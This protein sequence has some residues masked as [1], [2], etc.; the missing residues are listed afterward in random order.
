MPIEEQHNTQVHLAV[1]NLFIDGLNEVD[2]WEYFSRFG[3]ISD[4]VIKRNSDGKL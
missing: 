1:K 2:L 3:I 4:V